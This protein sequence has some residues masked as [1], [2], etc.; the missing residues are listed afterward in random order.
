MKPYRAKVS[1]KGL[2][3]LHRFALSMIVWLQTEIN[4]LRE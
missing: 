3:L 4:W 1:E 2:F